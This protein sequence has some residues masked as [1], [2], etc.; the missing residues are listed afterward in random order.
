MA[1][2]AVE[3]LVQGF[4]KSKWKSDPLPAVLRIIEQEPA[5]L[6]ALVLRILEAIPDGGTFL[7]Q[8]LNHLPERDF[9]VVIAAA[10]AR[11]AEAG[12]SEA[13]A[14]VIETAALQMPHLLRPYLRRLFP[15]LQG[16]RAY[17]ATWPWRGADAAEIA[18]L[19]RV[20]ESDAELATRQHAFDCLLQT[21]QPEALRVAEARFADVHTATGKGIPDFNAYAHTVG[22][23]IEPG[24]PDQL[25]ALHAQAC[26]HLRFAPGYFED[27]QLP[28]WRAHH[29]HATWNLDGAAASHA[30]LGGVLEGAG[31]RCA[32]CDQPLHRLLAFDHVPAGLPVSLPA[33]ELCACLSCLGWEERVLY[34]QHDAQ[35]R[36]RPVGYTGERRQP[37]FVTLGFK[38]ARVDLLET[39]P[40]WRAQDWGQ[41]NG[42]QNLH[43]VGGEPCW[44]QDAEYPACCDCGKLMPCIAQLDS[45][46]PDAAGHDWLWG[47]GGIGYMFWCDACRISACCLQ[48]T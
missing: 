19:G 9:D 14:T 47:S 33:L 15:L 20:I 41:S 42:N 13:A 44:I 11:L 30:L 5:A 48:H 10:V 45:D 36:P 17:S 32:V 6:R 26:W 23:H 21:R 22:Y 31:A 34:Y 8:A 16:K 46:L 7:D 40:R 28:E 39:P 38:Q 24:A 35:G 37:E 2:D 18:Q 25:V 3:A 12:K 27:R 43:R 29:R 1:V 4:L